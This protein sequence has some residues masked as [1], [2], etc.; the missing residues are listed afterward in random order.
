MRGISLPLESPGGLET[1]GNYP[2]EQEIYDFVSGTLP[3]DRMEEIALM[4]KEDRNLSIEIDL[5]FSKRSGGMWDESPP[6][7]PDTMFS[8]ENY[9]TKKDGVKKNAQP[10][11]E[12]LFDYVNGL[13]DKTRA[14]E[15]AQQAKVDSELA[16]AIELVRG[17][18]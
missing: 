1:A 2:D 14:D 8:T 13:L 6:E 7:D 11:H 15:I 9:W 10:S 12:E 18:G 3:K 16:A 5:V 17:I 4:A